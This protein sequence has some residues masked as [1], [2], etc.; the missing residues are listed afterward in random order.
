MSHQ[1]ETTAS[2]EGRSGTDALASSITIRIYNKNGVYFET[3]YYP[4]I[5][6]IS[7]HE[8]KDEFAAFLKNCLAQ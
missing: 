5:G 1:G 6:F 7:R 8:V 2:Y 4:N 3:V